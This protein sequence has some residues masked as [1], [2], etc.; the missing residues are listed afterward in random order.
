MNITTWKAFRQ[1]AYD[2]LE[3]RAD[4]LLSEAQARSLA[5]L[6][7]SPWFDHTWSSVYAA[8]AEQDGCRGIAR[9]GCAQ[10]AGRIAR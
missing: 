3:C 4:A 9:V 6:S 10:C 7:L 1:Q 2:C 5:E 8:L